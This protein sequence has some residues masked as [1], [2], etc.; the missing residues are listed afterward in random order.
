MQYKEINKIF[1]DAVAKTLAQGYTICTNTMGGSQGEI[2][3]VNFTDKE[4]NHYSLMMDEESGKWD[5]GNFLD[6]I[7]IRFVQSKELK[8]DLKGSE[9]TTFWR[10]DKYVEVIGERKFYK[11]SRRGDYFVEGESEAKSICERRKKHWKQENKDDYRFEFEIPMNSRTRKMVS[12]FWRAGKERGEKSI[13]QTDINFAKIVRDGA[14]CAR[15]FI[16]NCHSV[17]IRYAA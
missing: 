12:K 11:V 13:K 10:A 3:F 6:Y 15:L 16:N 2:A 9:H 1:S 8:G 4:G 14:G 7:A 5:E 17:S